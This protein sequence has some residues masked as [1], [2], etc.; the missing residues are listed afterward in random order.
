MRPKCLNPEKHD[1]VEV[2]MR[3]KEAK[4][5]REKKKERQK[6]QTLR[7]E[8]GK[9]RHTWRWQPAHTRRS[10]P[11]RAKRSFVVDFGVSWDSWGGFER[12]WAGLGQTPAQGSTQ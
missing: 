5:V 12:A 6:W 9:E 4:C 3:K 8:E 7:E 10:S 2:T 11:A 1:A